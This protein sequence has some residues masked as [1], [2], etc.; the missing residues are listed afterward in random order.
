[1]NYRERVESDVFMEAIEPLLP[2]S[3]RLAFALVHSRSDAEDIV[4]EATLNA[5]KHRGSLHLGSSVRPWFLAIVANQCR[6][7]VR[8]RWWSVIR[9]SDLA[10]GVAQGN[11][12]SFD[13]ADGLRKGL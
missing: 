6:Q 3:Y 7:A 4:Q 5:W 9:R 12:I 8:T 13:E 11:G 1:M 2:M 10:S